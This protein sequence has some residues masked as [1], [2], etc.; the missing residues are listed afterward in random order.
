MSR[1]GAAKGGPVVLGLE[2]GRYYWCRCGLSNKQP[3]CDGAHI[4][5]GQFTP[6]VFD[7]TERR[8]RSYCLCKQTKQ[9]PFCDG[10]HRE[11][12]ENNG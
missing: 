4:K 7:I 9:P 5:N 6:V 2:P 12:K 10:S 8:R 3:F 11:A 1:D